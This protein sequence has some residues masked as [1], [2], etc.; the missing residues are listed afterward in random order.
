MD[1][2]AMVREAKDW[3]NMPKQV[4]FEQLVMKFMINF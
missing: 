2:G 4:I 1:S 3:T